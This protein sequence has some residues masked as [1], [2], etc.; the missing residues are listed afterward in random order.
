MPTHPLLF[1]ASP[2][3][4][5]AWRDGAPVTV[6]GFLA[7]VARVAAALP[8]GGHV[9]NV[10]RDRYRFAVSLCA[11][12]VAR[13]ISL[14]PSNHTPET[15]RQLAAFAPDTFCLHDSPDCA[16]DLPRFQYPDTAVANLNKDDCRDSSDAFVVP[17]IDAARVMAYVFTSGSTGAPVPHRKTWGCLVDGVRA[18][19]QSLGLTGDDAAAHTL[20]GTVPAQHMYGFESTVLLALIGGLAFSSRQPFYA[21]D[22]RA[23]LDAVPQPRVLVTSPIHLRTLLASDAP[24]PRAALVLSATAPLAE[25]L[26]CEAEARLGA[27]LIEIYGST[28]TGQI[29]TRRTARGAV[30][31]LLPRIRLNALKAR[32]DEQQDQEDST[33]FW[34]SGGHLDEPVPMGDALEL[35][36]A[37]RFLL[38]GRKQDLVNIAGKRTSLA[39]LNHQLN[40]IPGVTDGVFFMPGDAADAADTS[41]TRLVALV[42]APSLNA[43]ELQRA[44]RERIDAAFLPRPLVFVDALSRNETGK[45]PRDVLA[46]LAARHTRAAASGSPSPST[47]ES[48]PAKTRAHALR[49]TIGADHPALP[50]HF[51]GQP[52]VPGVVLLDRAIDAIG[53]ALDQPL[54]TWRLSAAKFLSPAAPGEALDLAFDAAA[55]GAIRF[56]VRAGER[57]VASGTL[58]VPSVHAEAAP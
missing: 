33:T 1:H 34:A 49:F 39:Y 31:Q 53:A 2:R 18:S 11:A 42:V 22:I 5:I 15:V 12:L 28:E 7:D 36:D 24:L 14:L 26:A 9:F 17:Q 35:L 55:S 37:Q 54:D 41:I 10:C 21:A 40:A 47:C 13:R 8:P 50:G 25:K 38:H 46:A 30:W 45:L 20:V 43:A 29:A 23:E 51:P 58:A 48:A 4:V 44:L 52:I 16:I 19:A 57:D 6:R 3:Q 56:T 27:P 32:D